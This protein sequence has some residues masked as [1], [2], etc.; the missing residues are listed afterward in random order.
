MPSFALSKELTVSS[1]SSLTERLTSVFQPK[2]FASPDFSTSA[3]M[4]KH[5][6]CLNLSILFQLL[7]TY[8]KIKCLQHNLNIIISFKLSSILEAA[9]TLSPSIMPLL[10]GSIW[11]AWPQLLTAADNVFLRFDGSKEFFELLGSGEWGERYS[12]IA[13][14]RGAP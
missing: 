2:K 5:G 12:C 13:G 9:P 3:K 10:L 14:Y 4:I 1:R 8:S 7:S 11:A 6:T